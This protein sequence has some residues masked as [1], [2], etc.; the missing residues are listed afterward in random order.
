MS[1]LGEYLEIDEKTGFRFDDL[2]DFVEHMNDAD[3]AISAQERRE[4]EVKLH[5]EKE[6]LEQ[7]SIQLELDRM[8]RETELQIMRELL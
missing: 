8:R 1:K 6:R 7:V 2:I 4:R 5:R 3:R